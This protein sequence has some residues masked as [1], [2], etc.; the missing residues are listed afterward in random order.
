VFNTKDK[1][2]LPFHYNG[3]SK[4]VDGRSKTRGVLTFHSHSKKY[5]WMN[6]LLCAVE[7]APLQGG[8]GFADT[9]YEWE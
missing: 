3:I 8:S 9:G 4:E 6:S 2:S 1:E 7:S 5:A